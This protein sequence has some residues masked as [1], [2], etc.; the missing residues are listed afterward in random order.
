MRLYSMDLI[1]RLMAVLLFAVFDAGALKEDSF[2]T[3]TEMLPS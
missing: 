2:S 3:V 1:S